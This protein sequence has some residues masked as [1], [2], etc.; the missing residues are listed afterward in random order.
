M[1]KHF[2]KLTALLMAGTMAMTV[3]AGCGNEKN[4]EK[5]NTLEENTAVSESQAAEEDTETT[6]FSY[7]LE[8]DRTITYSAS[9]TPGL[10]TLDDISSFADTEWAKAAGE[11]TGVTVEWMHQGAMD[12]DEW[13]NFMI[14]DGEYPDVMHWNWAGYP[15]GLTAA[16]EEGIA[17]E[18]TDVI[19]QYMPNYKAWL[20]ANP[21]LANMLKTDDGKYYAI[22]WAMSD[23]SMGATWGVYF[24]EDILNEMGEKVPETI[25]EWHDLL[26]KVKEQYNMNFAAGTGFLKEGVFAN[27]YISTGAYVLNPET[28]EIE[29]NYTSDAYKE[30]LT[31]MAQ[32]YKEGLI[33]SDF[34]TLDNGTIKNK[35]LNN[36]TF[37]TL[38]WAGSGMQATMLEGQELNPDFSLAAAPIAKKDASS[39]VIYCRASAQASYSNAAIITTQCEDVEAAARYLDYWWSEE[40]IMLSNF[41]IEGISYTMENGV[42][43]YTEL[44]TNNPDG[45]SMSVVMEVYF[46]A[47]N[48]FPGIQDYNYLQGFY[49]LQNVKDCLGLWGGKGTNQYDLD[50]LGL[51]FTT[52]ESESNAELTTAISTRADEMRLKFVLGEADIETEWDAYVADI[53]AMKVADVL[54]NYKTSYERWQNR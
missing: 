30:F 52:E 33:D 1:K 22:P 20:E 9:L 42:P 44:I 24:R 35:I 11:A 27:A 25:E 26:V 45:L 17:I 12:G 49:Q 10:K 3:L 32:W 37:A 53:E 47:S 4:V 7:P 43:T 40:G 23:P 50:N 13:F 31:V 14:M 54:E 41:G 51:S 21:T 39:E 28:G 38:G 19:D 18:L 16:Y 46:R 5:E 8:G 15:G 48:G 2:Q 6:E 34:A 36:E 29:Y